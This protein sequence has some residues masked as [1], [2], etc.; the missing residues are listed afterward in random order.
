MPVHDGGLA[1]LHRG[2]VQ[3]R[4]ADAGDAIVR[5]VL[6]MVPDFGVEQQRLG[7]DA[8]HVQAGAAEHGVALDER[9]LEAKLSAAN[10]RG[11]ACGTAAE[12]GYVVNCVRQGNTPFR[13]RK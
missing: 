11:V 9:D 3:L 2:P 1:L 10:G 12:D 7:G 13:R 6:Q 4:R 5:R 8:A